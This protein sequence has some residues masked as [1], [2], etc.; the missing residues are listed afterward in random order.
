MAAKKTSAKTSAKKPSVK[1]SKVLKLKKKVTSTK[2]AKIAAVQAVTE[3]GV[4][5]MK[6]VDDPSDATDGDVSVVKA[7]YDKETGIITMVLV[8]S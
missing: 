6:S 2:P 8:D 3:F 5:T 4:V 1:A 7:V